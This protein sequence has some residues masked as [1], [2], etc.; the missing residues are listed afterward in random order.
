MTG[1]QLH[2]VVPGDIDTPT[3]GY[4]YDRRIAAGLRT[5]GWQVEIVSLPGTYPHTDAD[6]LAKANAAFAALPDNALVLVDG[7]AFARL[8]DVARRHSRRLRLAALVHHPLADEGNLS[9][10]IAHDFK[11]DEIAA[12]ENARAVI[13][14]S[15]TTGR[16]LMDAYGVS[17]TQLH[18]APPGTERK[19]LLTDNRQ[20]NRLL[21]VA[22]IVQRKGHDVLIEAFAL[23]KNHDWTAR[24]VGPSR[25]DLW[26]ARLDQQIASRGLGDRISFTGRLNDLD[27]EYAAAGIFVLATRH[28]GYGMAYAEALAA[29]LPVVGCAVGAVPEVVPPNAGALVPSDNASAFADALRELLEKDNVYDSAAE[30]ARAAAETLPRWEDSVAI[31]ARALEGIDI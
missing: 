28:E 13:C 24:F 1:R 30:G 22:S 26:R 17:S 19:S 11:T 25:D 16:R 4:G 3:G 2:F 15:E 29:G 20:R 10:E 21:C 23:L 27:P 9:E 31:I 5:L 6:T 7:L 8:P 12:L 18:I 14:T